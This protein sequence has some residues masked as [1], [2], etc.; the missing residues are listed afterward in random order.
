MPEPPRLSAYPFVIVRIACGACNRSGAYRLARLAAKYGPEISL[1]DLLARLT[2]DCG[3]R[4]SKHP[5]AGVCRARFVDLD[6]PT[7]PPD[8]PGRRLR[9]IVG[10]RG[11]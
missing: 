3:F 1:D 7:R 11:E 5:V 8:A 4:E 2:A 9:V 10:G 6:P